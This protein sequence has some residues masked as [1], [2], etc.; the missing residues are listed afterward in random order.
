VKISNKAVLLALSISIMLSACGKSA[1]PLADGHSRI[2]VKCGG[3]SGAD[4]DAVVQGATI[5][6]DEEE[7][8]CFF[9]GEAYLDVPVPP[10]IYD[11]RVKVDTDRGPQ[12]EKFE[13]VTF[14]ASGQEKTIWFYDINIS[15]PPIKF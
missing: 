3:F 9:Y 6:V 15:S 4:I 7:L 2:E 1:G 14:S 5:P 13:T 10:T 12:M 8:S 11:V